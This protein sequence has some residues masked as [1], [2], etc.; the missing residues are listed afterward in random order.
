MKIIGI[1]LNKTGTKTLRYYLRSWGFHHKSFDKDAFDLYRHGNVKVVLDSMEEFDSFEDWPWPL[2]YR[3]IDARF[4][5]ARFILTTRATPQAWYQSLCK[6]AVRMGP[7]DQFEKHIYG[8]G[9]P[10]ANRR[11]HVEFYLNH[12]A[13]AEEYF[14]KNP[15]KLLR[16]CWE[17]GDGISK[18]GRIPGA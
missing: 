2:M 17:Q 9:M 5:D 18:T 6:M 14:K 3:E 8:Y 13:Q 12:I 4:H 7:L 11:H 16:I 10:Q 1:G 15:S